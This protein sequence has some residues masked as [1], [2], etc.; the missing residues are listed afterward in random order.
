M[1]RQCRG[2]P[3]TVGSGLA[4]DHADGVFEGQALQLPEN[5]GAMRSHLLIP[6]AMLHLDSWANC[7]K[8]RHLLQP[9]V[10]AGLAALLLTP[11]IRDSVLNKSRLS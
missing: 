6:P 8:W 4:H 11:V 9:E 10:S 2:V 7:I 3:E 1:V 5:R